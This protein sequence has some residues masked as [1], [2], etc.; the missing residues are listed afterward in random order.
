MKKLA[1]GLQK[2]SIAHIELYFRNL[3]IVQLLALPGNTIFLSFKER[4]DFSKEKTITF[5]NNVLCL[6]LF[7][8][9]YMYNWA[10]LSKIIT[11]SIL[12]KIL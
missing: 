6:Y 9:S 1:A 4:E 2:S 3:E 5:L 7:F 8:F 10:V 12:T 11:L